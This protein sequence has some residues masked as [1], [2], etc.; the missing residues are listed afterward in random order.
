MRRTG[1]RL[2]LQAAAIV[3]IIV[4]TLT[5]TAVLVVLHSQRNEA[6]TLLDQALARAIDVVDPP[7]G[8]WLIARTPDGTIMA[9]PGLPVGLRDL[10]ALQRTAATGTPD[11]FDRHLDGRD[12][13]VRI[14]R[15]GDGVTLEAIL[16][17]SANQAEQS[18][19]VTA[20]LLAGGLGLLLAAAAGAW[21][22]ARATRPLSAA[23][24]LQRRFVS[25]ASHELRTPLTL[26]STRAQLLRRR[27][28]AGASEPGVLVEAD[29]VVDHA[30]RLAD[31]LDDLLLAADPTSPRPQIEVDLTALAANV[32]AES[33]P[34]RP[35][36]PVQVTGPPAPDHT[37]GHDTVV[38]GSPIALH[39]AITALV[40][41]GVRHANHTV[42]VSVHR[43]QHHVV[44]EVADDGPGVD[45]ELAPRL[46]ERFVS[47]HVPGT[48]GRRHYG[49]GLALVSESVTS[50]GGTVEL[51]QPD[52]PGAV[53]RIT[54]PSAHRAAR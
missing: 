37:T 20:M 36:S 50:H 16:D 29:H 26:L 46:F 51:T 1:R 25:D 31:I 44:L 6:N 40:D 48:E 13:R 24:A 28:Q 5:A 23:L 7:A 22:G 8:V 52:R 34:D 21:L 14:V 41:N 4:F 2:G 11:A 32:V 19:L 27:L 53:F 38:R 30:Q 3:S 10:T 54:L 33:E 39:R 12:Y 15:R 45:P 49:L 18:R 9:T 17:L 43:A 35:N 47:T 42:H